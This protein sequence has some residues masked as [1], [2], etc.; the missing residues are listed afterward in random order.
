MVEFSVEDVGCECVD[1]DV[2][3]SLFDCEG[4]G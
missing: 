2:V 4:V 3:W 1:V